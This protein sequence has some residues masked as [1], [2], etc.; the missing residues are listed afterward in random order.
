MVGY[1][2]RNRTVIAVIVGVEQDRQN[3]PL[4]FTIGSE[5]IG[6]KILGVLNYSCAVSLFVSFMASPPTFFVSAVALLPFAASL[7]GEGLQ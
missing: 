1:S 2:L 3:L 5:S 7:K 4:Q 6:G